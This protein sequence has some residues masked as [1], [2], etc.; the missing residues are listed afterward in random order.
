MFFTAA[1][2]AE[3]NSPQA[4]RI[5]SALKSPYI[6]A[7]LEFS[8]FVLGDLVGLNMLFHS[9]RF[10]LHTLLPELERV[11]IIFHNNFMKICDNMRLSNVDVNDE[12]KWVPLDQVY[13]GYIASETLKEMLPHQREMFLVRCK[14]WYRE[15]IHQIRKRIDISD[16]ILSAL[17]DV[18]HEKLLQGTASVNSAGILA[19]FLPLI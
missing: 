13:P 17:Q 4:E 3:E 16:P 6:K 14:G 7:T 1:E 18:G 11:L 5:L 10:Q 2:V 19:K 9:K 12:H 15:A 8:E